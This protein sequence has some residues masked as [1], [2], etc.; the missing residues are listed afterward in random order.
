M[1]QVF[2][3]SDHTGVTV[4]VL[5]RSLL[6]RFGGLQARLTTRPFVD[7]VPKARAVVEEL[8]RLDGPAVVFTSIALPD[9]SA[10]LAD[11]P[12]LVLDVTAPFL[13]RLAD[14]F[15]TAPQEQVGAF[16]RVRDVGKYQARIAAVEYALSTDDGLGVG[17]YGQAELILVGASRAG[18]TPTSLYLALHH[19]VFVANYPLTFDDDE[20]AELPDVL[21]PH[22]DRLFGLTIDP[23]RL[24]QIRRERR[25]EGSYASMERCRRDVAMAEAVFRR[26]DVP[27]VNTTALSVE[28][29]AARILHLEGAGRKPDRT[30][31]L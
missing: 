29:I 11:A 2:F 23:V 1:Q 6:A 5:G 24:H 26:Y 28:E 3:V 9:V 13:G 31:D 20:R 19:G 14:H 15:G 7:T 22:R 10:A 16:H 4:E 25:P 18:K 17:H 21:R 30:R 12:G 8:R 27:S